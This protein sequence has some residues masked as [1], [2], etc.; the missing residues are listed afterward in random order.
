MIRF[1]EKLKTDKNGEKEPE[2]VRVAI[3]PSILQ[4]FFG[5][6]YYYFDDVPVPYKKLLEEERI[7]LPSQQEPLLKSGS[8]SSEEIMFGHLWMRFCARLAKHQ[9]EFNETCQWGY[10]MLSLIGFIAVVI[11]ILLPASSLEYQA[12]SF[13][14]LFVGVLL[15]FV[16]CLNVFSHSL[17][18][19]AFHLT[20]ILLITD[21][22]D[23]KF[24]GIGD[25]EYHGIQQ[26]VDDMA[27]YF[28]EQ[29]YHVDYVLDNRQ[30]CPPM[31]YVRFTKSCG[32]TSDDVPL[33]QGMYDAQQRVRQEHA[34]TLV[35]KRQSQ[36]VAHSGQFVCGLRTEAVLAYRQAILLCA[37][38]LAF[39]FVTM[40]ASQYTW[41]MTE[42]PS[43]PIPVST[44]TTQIRSRLYVE[45]E[46]KIPQKR[47]VILS[48][49][50]PQETS[51]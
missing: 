51:I 41:F 6:G 22:P 13:G 19:L 30:W 3:N 9:A 45:E 35:T 34:E 4:R 42:Y 2:E 47:N 38:T 33:A 32:A 39:F 50:Q 24:E 49:Q 44:T 43:V 31:V 15:L 48:L 18:Q 28:S 14:N 7:L 10:W 11:L 23:D 8:S 16:A 20:R 37:V 17:D 36:Q 29:G 1:Y 46:E 40:H 12:D 26:L 27:P 5:S 25:G 21:V